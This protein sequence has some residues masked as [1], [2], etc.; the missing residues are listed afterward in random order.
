VS[1]KHSKYV[2][3]MMMMMMMMPWRSEPPSGD[4]SPSNKLQ[5]LRHKQR[6]P[7]SPMPLGTTKPPVSRHH[8][9][10][11][12][13]V[14]FRTTQ[15]IS[16]HQPP[17]YFCLPHSLLSLATTQPP[18]YVYHRACYLYAQP[19]HLSPCTTHPPISWYHPTSYHTNTGA[20]FLGLEQQRREA[21]CRG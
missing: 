7:T 6:V 3:L 4:N 19:I 12:F 20:S 15:P 2:Y 10:L 9:V 1:L 13:C 18:T 5:H 17:T 8:P 21:S 11:Y 16:R 14:P